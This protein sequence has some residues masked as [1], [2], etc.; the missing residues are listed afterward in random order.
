[1]TVSGL[2]LYV[3]WSLAFAGGWV[4]PAGHIIEAIGV[5]SFLAGAASTIAFLFVSFWKGKR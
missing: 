4:A 3:S 2:G 1:M 5:V